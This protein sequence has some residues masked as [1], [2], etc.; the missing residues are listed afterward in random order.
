MERLARTELTDGTLLLRPWR[1]EDVPR[2]TE[3]CQDPEIPRWT[4]VI[5]EPYTEEHARPR[6]EQTTRD[7]EEGAEAAFALTDAGS[8]EVLGAIGLTLQRHFALQASIG[9]WVAKRR[10]AEASRP[11][12][13]GSSRAGD[14]VTS[15]CPACN[16]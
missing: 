13:C 3:A 6:I 8:G 7:W 4:A 2:V 9:Y 11:T 1:L 10:A 14:C 15:V 16:S 5:P 12:H